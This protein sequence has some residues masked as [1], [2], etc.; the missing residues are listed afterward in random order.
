MKARGGEYSACKG[1]TDVRFVH[2]PMENNVD[3]INEIITKFGHR[4]TCVIFRSKEFHSF[5]S[6]VVVQKVNREQESPL[7]DAIGGFNAS[8]YQAKKRGIIS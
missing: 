8:V 5:P 3:L 6:W 4:K 7:L 1:Y 2:I